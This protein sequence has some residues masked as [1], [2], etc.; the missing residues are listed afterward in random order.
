MIERLKGPLRGATE[1]QVRSPKKQE[2]CVWCFNR[3]RLE[4]LSECQ[5]AGGYPWLEPDS[6]D[7][8]EGGAALPSFREMREWPAEARLAMLYLVVYYS[9]RGSS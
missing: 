2:I 3:N 5:P 6:P 1:E 4:C 7:T 8:W 9:L